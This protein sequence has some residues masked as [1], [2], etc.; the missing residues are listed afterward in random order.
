MIKVIL[1]YGFII[2]SAFPLLS[3]NRKPCSV[4]LQSETDQSFRSDARIRIPRETDSISVKQI[5][6][7]LYTK[8]YLDVTYKFHVADSSCRVLIDP[9]KRYKWISLSKGNM[10]E[11][12]LHQANVKTGIFNDR[13]FK[14]QA[15]LRMY[16][17]V[18]N[19]SE[20]NGYPF[21]TVGLKRLKIEEEGIQAELDYLPGHHINFDTLSVMGTRNIS[22]KFLSAYLDILPGNPYDR[23]KVVHILP[24][25]AQLPGIRLTSLPEEYFT[26]GKCFI[27]LKLTPKAANGFD[28]YLGFLPNENTPGKVLITGQIKLALNNLFRSGKSLVLSWQRP[29]LQTQE[30]NL[31]YDHPC[32]FNS[33]VSGNFRFNIYKQDTSYL[34]TGFYFGLNIRQNELGKVGVEAGYLTTRILGSNFTPQDTLF[35]L[36]DI[37]TSYYGINYSYTR[38]NN[39]DFPLN[40]WIAGLNVDLGIKKILNVPD[41]FVVSGNPGNK[42]LQFKTEFSLSKYSRLNFRSTI[43]SKISGGYLNDGDLYIPDLFRLGG[44]TSL[45]GFNE[46]YFYSSQYII[47]NFEYRLRI[48]MNSYLLVF[49]DMGWIENDLSRSLREDWPMGIGGGLNIGTPLGN[50]AII[51]ALGKDSSQ[52]F[53]LSYSKIHIGY[54]GRF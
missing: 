47:S 45:R 38:I 19:W 34:N 40:G 44:L 29:N 22:E 20:N 6:N 23:S 53:N 42:R 8:G 9:G 3:Q 46:K 43:L 28:G 25:L 52:A 37:N 51:Y 15:L 35:K 17:S 26:A 39:V 54:V 30:L 31:N 5:I 18:L 4:I 27:R 50:L 16:R 7:K 32:L 36:A 21:A 41:T 1:I 48:E 2:L 11:S 24:S 10:P 12:V 13:I 33:P 14:F 49:Y